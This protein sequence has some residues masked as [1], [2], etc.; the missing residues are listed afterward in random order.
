M[1]ERLTYAYDF[2]DG[3]EHA[4][5]VEKVLP[6]EDSGGVLGWAAIVAAVNDPNHA[7]YQEYRDWLGLP[8]GQLIDPKYFDRYALDEELSELY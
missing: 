4:I 6:A 1:R 7:E 8:F 5:T 3:W 2:G